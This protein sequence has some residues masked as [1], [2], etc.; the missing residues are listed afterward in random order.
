MH[1][2]F[3]STS[4]TLVCLNF[5]HTCLN[6]NHPRGCEIVSHCVL[7][8]ISLMANDNGA[9]FHVLIGHLHFFFGKMSFQ[10]LCSFFNWVVCLFL[11]FLG[12]R[13]LVMP[14]YPC[15]WVKEAVM[16]LRL[17]KAAS[18]IYV[19]LMSETF[20]SFLTW[21]LRECSLESHRHGFESS[22][23]T[24]KICDLE[25]TWLL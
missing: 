24:Y 7:I 1:W 5:I 9:S 16:I 6:V 17:R 15:Q 4:S 23:V 19:P 18:R 8:S 13:C 20:L 12:K 11:G 14:P 2:G 21:G 25:V 22:L 10:I 3:H